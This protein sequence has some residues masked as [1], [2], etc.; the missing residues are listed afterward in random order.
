MTGDYSQK[1]SGYTQSPENTRQHPVELSANQT[2]RTGTPDQIEFR[3][4][5]VEQRNQRV[6]GESITEMGLTLTLEEAES[7]GNWLLDAVSDSRNGIA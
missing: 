5:D 4:L 6:P 7:L 2:S 1:F 3:M